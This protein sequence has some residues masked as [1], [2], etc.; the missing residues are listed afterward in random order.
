MADVMRIQ[1]G[2]PNI[3]NFSPRPGFED[4]GAQRVSRHITLDG[5][6][7]QYI[8]G[9]KEQYAIPLNNISESDKDQFE[10][11][12]EAGT[13]LTFYH[14]YT[15]YPSQTNVVRIVNESKPLRMMSPHWNNVYEGE[16]ILRQSS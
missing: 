16:L 12:W 14:N 4:A 10:T 6:L 8:W 3:I 15:D 1:D 13:E 5:T 2:V 11:W 9:N 7:Y